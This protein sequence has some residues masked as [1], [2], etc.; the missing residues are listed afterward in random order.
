MTVSA[1][2]RLPS[3]LVQLV[4]LNHGGPSRN[5]FRRDDVF[6]MDVCVT[7]RRPNEH[8]R[9][10]D[11]WGPH[12]TAAL[13]SVILLPPGETLELTSAGGRRTSLICQLRADVVRRCLPADFEFTDRRLEACLDISSTTIRTL[14]HRLAQEIHHPGL[15]SDEL[16][17][18]VAVQLAIELARYLTDI[19]E[20]I[21][22]GGLASWRLRAIDRRLAKEGPPP[23][24]AE[25]GALCNLSPRQLTRAFR[26]SR[27]CSIGAYMAQS[28]IEAAKR[29]L[30]TDES[31]KSIAASM[32]FSS[33]STF[34]YAF[35][36][37]TGVTP[38]QFRTRV[39]RGGERAASAPQS[40]RATTNAQSC[41]KPPEGDAERQQRRQ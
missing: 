28:R 1:E 24:L 17:E 21:E 30:S 15:M 32:G 40:G 36:R 7:P 41:A 35:R 20:A 8:A 12:R 6:W 11:R 3:A 23:D 16:A 2:L 29:R 10:V 14:L 18:A 31:L 19:R 9:Y 4:R 5:T 26:A 22:T 38:G 25:L 27:G 39:L 13:G 37:A 33:H 34:T